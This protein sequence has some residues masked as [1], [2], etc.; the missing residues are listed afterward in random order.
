MIQKKTMLLSLLLSASLFLFAEDNPAEVLQVGTSSIT[1]KNE[2]LPLKEKWKEFVNNQK[3]GESKYSEGVMLFEGRD[4]IVASGTS[5]V[6][7]GIAQ[8]GWVESRII[9]FEQA[10]LDAKVKII[11]FLSEDVDTS[12]SLSYM[13]NAT[14]NDGT[15]EEIKQLNDV[16]ETLK[17]I[18]KKTLDLADA[19]L[20]QALQKMDPDYD[21]EKY[22]N[23]SS[24]KKHTILEQ[25]FKRKIRNVT[26]QTTIGITPVYNNEGKIDG[27]YEV[28]V[29]VVWSPN[30]NRLAQGLF[31]KTYTMKKAAPG[32]SIDEILKD[33]KLL[34]S[35]YGTHITIDENGDFIVLAYAQAAPRSTSPSRRASAVHDAKEV[36]SNRARAMIVNYIREG[37]AF[38]SS[39][40]SQ[41][42]L[43]EF[44]DQTVGVEILREVSRKIKGQKTKVNL[45]GLRQVKEWAEKHPE[46]EQWIAGVVIAWSPTSM[47]A[48]Q[49]M[50]EV[51]RAK[52]S[53]S[54]ETT[55]KKESS[56]E[57][58]S[59]VDLSSV[60]VNT[61]AY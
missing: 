10:E 12:R 38:S 25:K 27:A 34:M 44:S 55:V 30:L 15:I 41:E 5:F 26:F 29:G 35:N 1:E 21:K 52:P 7:V 57:D 22:A 14:W 48:S 11:R 23:I 13:E 2:T 4:L 17:R 51:M 61:S 42:L 40:Q 31:N 59:P 20:D 16:S 28:I 24:A 45:R 37:L 36:A 32:K 46:T 39:E 50:E 6:S 47:K 49:K 56:Q 8:P 54:K 53:A 43:R 18:G 58:L 33:S 3:W 19:S 60:P 9:A